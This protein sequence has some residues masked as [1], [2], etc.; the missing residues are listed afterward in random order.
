MREILTCP[1]DEYRL[2]TLFASAASFLGADAPLATLER[3]LV[4]R[5]EAA[6]VAWPGIPLDEPSF[7]RHLARHAED[8]LPP[9]ERA[10]E[11]G[12]VCACANGSPEAIA[13]LQERYRG[14]IERAAARVDPCTADEATQVV[15]TSLLVR[16]GDAPARIAAYGG[17]SSLATWLST[18]SARAAAKLR[19][20]PAQRPHESASRLKSPA[21]DEPPELVLLRGKYAREL[22]AA[23]RTALAGLEGR[24]RALL[25]LHHGE[26]WSLE[27]LATLYDISRATVARWLAAAREQLFDGAK[28][29]LRERLPLTSSEFG[30]IAALVGG[31]LDVSI[32]RLL[33]AD[34][35]AGA[36]TGWA[37]P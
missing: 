11:L 9:L 12:L 1:M 10:A 34:A 28:C 21:A 36:G 2:A 5:L 6:R 23:L 7:V 19:R 18:V 3:E 32:L 24:S 8:G 30:S 35:S 4:A 31:D 37:R 14:A 33:Q 22:A 15:F 13:T 29:H 25:R 26:G 17:R 16:E 20:G 27:Q